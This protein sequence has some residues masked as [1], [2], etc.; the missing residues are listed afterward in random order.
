MCGGALNQACVR[1]SQ[2]GGDISG[3]APC[4]GQGRKKQRCLATWGGGVASHSQTG[5]A[6]VG[7]AAWENVLCSENVNYSAV[8]RPRK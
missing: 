6:G 4:D 7:T 5:A 2:A 3:P 1:K 8:A